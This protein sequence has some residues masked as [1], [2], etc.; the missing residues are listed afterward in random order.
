MEDEII[1]LI[2]FDFIIK[3]NP[4]NNV[5]NIGISIKKTVKEHKVCQQL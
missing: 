3:D 5:E 2:L 4:R 1:I